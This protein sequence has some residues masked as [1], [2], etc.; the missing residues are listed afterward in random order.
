MNSKALHILLLAILSCTIG[1]KEVGSEKVKEASTPTPTFE[2]EKTAILATINN[3]TKAAF[4][5]DYEGWKDKWVHEPFVTK[6][7]MQLTDSSSSETLG[8]DEVDRFVR[9]YF[10]AHPEPDPI[11]ALLEDIGVRLYGT[12]AWVSFEQEDPARGLKRE[13]RLMEKVEG[14]WK[15]AGMHTTIYGFKED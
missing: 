14:Q 2:Q 9:E 3:E 5:R 4:S 12:G 11:P 7:Y 10:I 15:I 6:T 13:T 8:W 1:C